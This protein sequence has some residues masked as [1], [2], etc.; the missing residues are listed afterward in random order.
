MSN[1]SP[2]KKERQSELPPAGEVALVQGK[3]FRCMA[4]R[5]K[6]GKWRD[7]LRRDELPEPIKVLSTIQS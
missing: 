4:Y 1:Q 2:K 6:D 7:Y 5:D 3:G